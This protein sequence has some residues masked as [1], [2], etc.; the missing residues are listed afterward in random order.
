MCAVA[1][2]IHNYLSRSI[3]ATF[4]K[5]IGLVFTFAACEFVVPINAACYTILGLSASSFIATTI[6]VPALCVAAFLT[7]TFV[8]AAILV[9]GCTTAITGECSFV[10]DTVVVAHTFD[11]NN[12]APYL[13]LI[14]DLHAIN[15]NR[16]TYAV[17]IFFKHTV[18]ALMFTILVFVVEAVA[19]LLHDALY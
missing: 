3:V 15:F 2:A 7:P 8:V 14:A 9:A 12:F 17:H 11:F 4:I 13:L 5:P 16:A 19:I 10:I 1:M 18:N 6:A